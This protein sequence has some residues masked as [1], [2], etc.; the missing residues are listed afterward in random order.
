MGYKTKGGDVTES[1]WLILDIVKPNIIC[2]Y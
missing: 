1:K 2:S